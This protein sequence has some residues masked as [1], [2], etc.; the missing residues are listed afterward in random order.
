MRPTVRARTIL[1]SLALTLASILASVAT[2]FADGGAT[3]F[4]K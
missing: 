2:V 3:P 1:V 4:P